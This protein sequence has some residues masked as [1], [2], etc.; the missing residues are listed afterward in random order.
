LEREDPTAAWGG[1]RW[2]DTRGHAVSDATKKE[3]AAALSRGCWASGRSRPKWRSGTRAEATG[4]LGPKRTQIKWPGAGEG[5][6]P[7]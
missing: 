5:T 4:R 2:P 3:S 7:R 1:R 6:R